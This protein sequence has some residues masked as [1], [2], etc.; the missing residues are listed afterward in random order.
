MSVV[1]LLR[2]LLPGVLDAQVQ[3]A[4]RVGTA[5]PCPGWHAEEQH[6]KHGWEADGARYACPGY[7]PL[8]D[9][10][11]PKWDFNWHQPPRGCGAPD[12]PRWDV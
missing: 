1:S 11:V 7:R 8:D 12:G 3:A 4:A 6:E 5:A 2:R 9:G 10:V